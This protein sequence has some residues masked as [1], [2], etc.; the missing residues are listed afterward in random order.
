MRI[1]INV[2]SINS[3]PSGVREQFYGLFNELIKKMNDTEFVLYEPSDFPVGKQFEKIENVSSI[4]TTIPSDKRLLKQLKSLLYWNI[5]KAHEKLDIFEG[6]SLPFY[7]PHEPKGL[8]TIYDI[9]GI[10]HSDRLYRSIYTRV[11]RNAL[12]SADQIITISQSM[13]SEILNFEP[14]SNVEIVYCGIN[15]SLFSSKDEISLKTIRLKLNLPKEFI[16]AVGHLEA[17]KDYPTLIEAVAILKRMGLKL[18]LVIVGN[19]NGELQ[20]I[21][22]LI[23]SKDLSK[24]V[25]LLSGIITEDLCGLYQLCNLFVFPS[26]YEGFGIPVL[27]AMASGTPIILSDISVFKE[28]TENKLIYFPVGNSESLANEIIKL[29]NKSS[30][31]ITMR[32]YGIRRVLDFNFNQLA[33]KQESIYDKLKG[34]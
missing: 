10:H 3:R 7:K 23:H 18:P 14:R 9:R 27:E 4:A 21:N 16:L 1:G 6:L 15:K 31:L 29:I 22:S 30:D 34:L 19:D 12:I 17:R 26:R 2:T 33:E 20:K 5:T 13:K 8:L 24:E 11:L 28:I 32:D 25:I